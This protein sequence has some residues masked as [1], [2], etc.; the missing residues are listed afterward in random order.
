VDTERVGRSEDTSGSDVTEPDTP[1]SE[2]ALTVRPGRAAT[3]SLSE[4]A[5]RRAVTSSC[6][7][8]V[9][10]SSGIRAGSVTEVSGSAGGRAG[11]PGRSAAASG[12][13]GSNTNS[14]SPGTRG[15]SPSGAGTP[16]DRADHRL[17]SNLDT[18][19]NVI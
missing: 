18:K 4:V 7:L 2:V 3:A 14:G 10:V 16:V 13:P 1:G 15:S 19:Q 6:G 5:G 17:I 11:T 12:K 8:G 9:T